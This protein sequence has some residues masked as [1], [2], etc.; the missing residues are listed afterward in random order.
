[1]Y[2]PVESIGGARPGETLKTSTEVIKL[3]LATGAEVSVVREA[4][5]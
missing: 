2:S 3:K 5:Q 4:Y 1:M